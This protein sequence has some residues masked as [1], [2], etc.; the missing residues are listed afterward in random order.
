[1]SSHCYSSVPNSQSVSKRV[2]NGDMGRWHDRKRNLVIAKWK[3]I[4]AN[5]DIIVAV[6]LDLKRAF[7]TIDCERLVMKLKTMGFKSRVKS[8]FEWYLNQRRQRTKR[9]YC[10]NNDLGVPQGSVLGAILFVLYINDLP[11]SQL[12]K[13]TN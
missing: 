13:A 10:V 12:L 2:K 6:F 1:M 5:G 11:S 9:T 7:E 4:S 8:W 3:E